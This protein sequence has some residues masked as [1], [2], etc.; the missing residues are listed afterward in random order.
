[1]STIGLNNVLL[2]F[3]VAGITGDITVLV[4]VP[5]INSAATC[6]AN[7]LQYYKYIGDYS[8]LNKAVASCFGGLFFLVSAMLPCG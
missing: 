3:M 1:M 6:L 5:I 2:G 7:G 4:L 8:A